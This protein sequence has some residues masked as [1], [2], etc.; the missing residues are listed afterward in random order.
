[1]I[2]NVGCD[3]CQFWLIACSAYGLLFFALASVN[4]S[5]AKWSSPCPSTAKDGSECDAQSIACQATTCTDQMFLYSDNSEL[6]EGTYIAASLTAVLQ[7][8]DYLDAHPTVNVANLLI[9]DSTIEDLATD[10]GYEDTGAY[11][12]FNSPIRYNG[13][14]L[15]EQ[16]AINRNISQNFRQTILDLDAV[17][18]R[19]MT[20]VAHSLESLAYLNYIRIWDDSWYTNVTDNRTRNVLD[21]DFPRLTHLTLRD[22]WWRF[23]DLPGQRTFFRPLPSLTHLHVVSGNYPSLS[24]VRQSAPNVTHI[25]FSGNLPAEY[26]PKRMFLAQWTRPLIDGFFRSANSPILIAQANLNPMLN[27]EMECGN[28]GIQHKCELSRLARNSDLHL[29]LAPE[30]DFDQ[31]GVSYSASRLFPLSRAIAEFEDRSSGGE[32]EWAIPSKNETEYYTQSFFFC[33]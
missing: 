11:S 20:R 31:Y 18:A 24:V 15:E 22:P 13:Q 7:L 21:R 1:M 25:R 3:L 12:L 27:R 16:E 28:P 10:F 2:G 5:Q 17:S 30:E 9:S 14:V 33:G 23:Q 26:S 19:I 6:P 4:V 32:G 8:A 29:K